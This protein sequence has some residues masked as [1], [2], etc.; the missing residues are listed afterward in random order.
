M[1]KLVYPIVLILIVFFAA[2][3]LQAQVL[4]SDNPAATADPASML[5][6]QSISKGFLFPRMTEAQRNA[7]TNPPTSMV[8]FQTNNT[9]G[10]YYNAGVPASPNWLRM[11]ESS[12]IGGYWSPDGSNIYF[13]TGNVGIGENSPASQLHVNGA[14]MFENDSVYITGRPG[15]IYLNGESGYEPAI[16]FSHNGTSMFKFHLDAPGS[17][18]YLSVTGL[19][20][21]PWGVSQVGRVWH[22]YP[23]SVQAH[24]L[25]SGASSS[26]LYID[27][28]GTATGSRGINAAVSDPS[29]NDE[30][31]AI[32]GWNLG[33][34]EGVYGENDTYGNFGY[35]GTNIHGA[36]GEY[37]T[38]SV[39]NR[40]AVGSEF[41][42]VWGEA[43]LTGHVGRLGLDGTG[44][45]WGVYGQDGAATDPNFGGIGTSNYGVYGEYNSE[46][47]W[48]VLG[49]DDA[50]VYATLGGPSQNLAD[51][52]FAVVGHGVWNSSMQGS[53]YN[54][55]QA[56]G[57][58]N[59]Y[60]QAGTTYSF[61]VAGY[62]T[63]L[64]G[65]NS[66][67]GGVLGYINGNGNWGALGY[68][69]NNGTRYGVYATTALSVG[70]GK[71]SGNP[72]Q[73]IG[74]GVFGDLFGAHV[75][76]E[77][78]GLYA[79]GEDYGIYADGD[80]YRTGADVHLQ[81]DNNGQNNVMY[82]LVSPEMT[83]QTY[84]IGQ[85]QNGKANV[86]FDDAFANIVSSSE[87]IIV[88]ITP[89]G[90]S[91]GV[92]LDR[93]DANGFMVEENESGK[94]SIQFTWIAIGKRA[95]YE[96]KSLPAD[97][98]ASDYNSKIERGLSKDSDPD[99]RAEGLYYQNGTLHN[100]QVLEARN[101]GNEAVVEQHK[102]HERFDAGEKDAQRKSSKERETAP[103]G[104]YADDQIK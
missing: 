65:A 4:V 102:Q 36:Y 74:L 1:K 34:G 32:G 61:G 100:G 20:E 73:D 21:D 85:L 69:A 79:K 101:S 63:D 66:R 104:K 89:I 80:M 71:S 98:I 17:N 35:L 27:A 53:G 15:R 47:F 60:N 9:P 95:G 13:D 55:N 7:I 96:N 90:K 54:S 41:S 51:G 91:K 16:R 86:E 12:Q 78:Y 44:T 39:G 84:G 103:K 18:P 45:D 24:V 67:T 2:P 43:G 29:A 31:L 14:S 59:G 70:G 26:T 6:V 62:T 25:I 33:E 23:G 46:D 68:R 28:Q 88:T 30:T 38:A 75:N 42:G 57:G 83:V 8:I 81:M 94:S 49:A 37:M 48:G 99:D 50:G 64:G 58:V 19:V 10:I 3:A 93:V 40:G 92:Y 11:K 5:D 76:G 82:T 97:V 22:S 87:P 52:D 56:I 77:V 72:L